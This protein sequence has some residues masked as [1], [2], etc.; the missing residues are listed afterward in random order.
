MLIIGSFFV[1]KIVRCSTYL[2]DFSL[3]DAQL[4]ELFRKVRELYD[5][6]APS[7]GVGGDGEDIAFDLALRAVEGQ[8]AGAGERGRVPL[9]GRVLCLRERNDRFL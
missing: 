4:I 9:R 3:H 2:P 7:Q 8:A 5:Q 1:S 6:H